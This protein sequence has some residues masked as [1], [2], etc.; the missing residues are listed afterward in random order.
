MCKDFVF[1]I[2]TVNESYYFATNDAK[3]REEWSNTILLTKNRGTIHG[4]KD[5]FYT[6]A[7][8]Q[9]TVQSKILNK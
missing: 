6:K 8:I 4:I 3:T 7:N 5:S 2:T 1:R 9:E